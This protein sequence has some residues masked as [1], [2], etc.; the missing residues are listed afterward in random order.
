M[1]QVFCSHCNLLSRQYECP[2]CGKH[3]MYVDDCF[4]AP[5]SWKLSGPYYKPAEDY[6]EK[7]KEETK[8]KCLEIAKKE[9]RKN[10]KV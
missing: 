8:K 1:S 6:L 10:E 3:G 5:E 7:I 9:V 4:G 2:S